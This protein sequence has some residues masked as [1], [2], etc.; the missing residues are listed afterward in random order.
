MDGAKQITET[1]DLER[2]RR[3]VFY[4]SR[5]SSVRAGGSRKNKNLADSNSE[6]G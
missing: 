6:A 5:N 1:P 3:K 4:G 2:G